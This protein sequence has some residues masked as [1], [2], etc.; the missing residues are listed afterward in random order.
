MLNKKIVI[1]LLAEQLKRNWFFV[2]NRQDL[3]A[4][5]ICHVSGCLWRSYDIRM[6]K[7]KKNMVAFGCYKWKKI[8]QDIDRPKNIKILKQTAIFKLWISWPTSFH[9]VDNLI[10]DYGVKPF[11]ESFLKLNPLRKAKSFT[12]QVTH[13]ASAYLQFL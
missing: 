9:T 5:L 6:I 2:T 1:K 3:M 4:S 8:S 13:R 11:L 7:T 10:S 12:S